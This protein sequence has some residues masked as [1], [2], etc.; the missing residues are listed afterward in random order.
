MIK[1]MENDPSLLL[2]VIAS[3][4]LEQQNEASLPEK[5]T[6]RGPQHLRRNELHTTLPSE[7][8]TLPGGLC[9]AF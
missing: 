9:A 1:A 6:V 4:L 5:G 7:L 8:D 3:M 2:R